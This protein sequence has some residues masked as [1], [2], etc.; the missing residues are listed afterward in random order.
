MAKPIGMPMA[1]QPKNSANMTQAARLMRASGTPSQ[2]VLPVPAGEPPQAQ[3]RGH[4]RSH[5]EQPEA[6][7]EQIH[8]DVQDERG[9]TPLVEDVVDGSGQRGDED[10]YKRG[11]V[12][13]GEDAAPAW[14]YSLV[15]HVERDVLALLD[16]EGA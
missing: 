10:G 14:P 11:D 5:H 2:R 6:G 12:D 1:H 13:D 3:E 15:E 9:L 4:D 7:I 16:D 8:A